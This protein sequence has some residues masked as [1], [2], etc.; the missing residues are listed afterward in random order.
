MIKFNQHHVTD[1]TTKARVLYS[2][3]NRVDGRKCVTIYAKDYSDAL[4]RVL[5][6]GYE[7]GTDIM[8]D[9]FE[10]GK[11]VL[12]ENHPH[13]AAARARAEANKAKRGH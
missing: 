8:T 5:P 11:V 12:F 13:Y 3:D 10:Q 7:N 4:W 6:E 9:Y 1:G 2:L